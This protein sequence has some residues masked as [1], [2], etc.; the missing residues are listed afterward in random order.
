[1][2]MTITSTAFRDQGEIPKQY[3]CAGSSTSPPLAVA[4][5][6][7]N[8]KTLALL[9]TDPDAP[10]GTFTHWVVWNMPGRDTTLA[11]GQK[12]PGSEGR[13]DY[14]RSG[15]GPPCPPSGTHR[16]VFDVYALD[17]S[18]DVSPSARRADVEKAMK[19]HVLAQ[20]QIVGTYH[21]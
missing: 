3:G 16:Y 17:T 12:P 2:A 9:M 6:P 10:G 21:K 13:S 14:G 11:E 15:Y 4:G 18:L 1:M 5:V 7:Q 8:A 19:G 20:A